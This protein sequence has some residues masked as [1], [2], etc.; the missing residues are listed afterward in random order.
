[1]PSKKI[2][3]VIITLF[4]IVTLIF[5]LI[6]EFNYRKTFKNYQSIKKEGISTLAYSIKT[7]CN[8]G[9]GL[10]P[11]RLYRYVVNNREYFIDTTPQQSQLDI[12]DKT[13]LGDSINVYYLPDNPSIKLSKRQLEQGQPSHCSYFI[14]S[15]ISSI[16][17]LAYWIG[18]KFSSYRE[19]KNLS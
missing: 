9:R 2:S 13:S 6:A 8:K 1:M 14:L 3:L 18:T 12:C 15:L 7:N 10:P 17:F 19:F 11:T 16:I 5:S 4:I